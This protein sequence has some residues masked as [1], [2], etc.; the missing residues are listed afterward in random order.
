MSGRML[1]V[2]LLDAIETRADSFAL[3][4]FLIGFAM[5]DGF[6]KHLSLAEFPLLCLV[7]VVA[8]WCI[9]CVLLVLVGYK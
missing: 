8:L 6:L 5:S 4:Y 7:E 9:S 1:R 3:R 2:L